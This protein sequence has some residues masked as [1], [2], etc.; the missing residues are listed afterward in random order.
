MLRT[1]YETGISRLNERNA[2]KALSPLASIKF[3]RRYG[4]AKI[5][6]DYGMLHSMNQ[7]VIFLHSLKNIEIENV[8]NA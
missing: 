3:T 8:P 7:A 6:H 4:S 5:A 1:I 2:V